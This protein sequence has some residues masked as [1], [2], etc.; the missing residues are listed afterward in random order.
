[1][2]HCDPINNKI[3]TLVLYSGL[4]S[5][6]DFILWSIPSHY[7][8]R[9]EK[10]VLMCTQNLTTLLDF[11]NFLSKHSVSMRLLLRVQ[12]TIGNAIQFTEFVYLTQKVR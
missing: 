10:A 12:L 3:C 8:T 6:D 11:F 4:D 1:M 2:V 5:H 7:G 9:H